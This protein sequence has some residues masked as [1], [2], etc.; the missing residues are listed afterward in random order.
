METF[1]IA[2][3][4]HPGADFNPRPHASLELEIGGR[5]RRLWLKAREGVIYFKEEENDSVWAIPRVFEGFVDEA[6]LVETARLELEA[7]NYGR[8]ETFPS[9]LPLVSGTSCVCV[10]CRADLSGF[11]KEWFDSDWMPFQLPQ[12][13]TVLHHW[14][15]RFGLQPH[16]HSIATQLNQR[17]AERRIE[18]VLRRDIAVQWKRGSCAELRRIVE[19]S[20]KL[21]TPNG[22]QHFADDTEFSFNYRAHSPNETGGLTTH[23]LYID[24]TPNDFQI[25]WKLIQTH[26]I[27]VG[28]A[29]ETVLHQGNS[30]SDLWQSQATAHSK[31]FGPNWRGHWRQ[32][33][34]N[35][36][37]HI[38]NYSPPSAHERLELA[39]ELQLWLQDKLP[40]P[41]I[42][43]L[44]HDALKG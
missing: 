12:R 14:E 19:V 6:Q 23:S 33:V 30:S 18:P 3:W 20:L 4:E 37:F 27:F 21:M 34:P 1:A 26:F 17:F 22:E 41:Q 35:K 25:L 5:V 9:H 16:I 7:G 39:L 10:V 31:R 40:A 44:L 11:A 24:A 36:G 32:N 15:S 8:Y 38:P 29:W 42:E 43:K 2:P 13:A 28:L